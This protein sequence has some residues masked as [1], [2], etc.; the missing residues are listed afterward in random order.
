M[1]TFIGG[2]NKDTELLAQPEGTYRDALNI[3]LNY[4]QGSVLNEEGVYRVTSTDK[5]IV[6]GFCV[7][8][9]DRIV[10][11]G[12]QETD[13][14]GSDGS[15]YTYF[16]QIKLLFP[17]EDYSIIL[18]EDS[19]LNFRRTHRVQTTHRK[20]QAGETLVYFTD[21]Y[22]EEGETGIESDPN[23]LVDFNP[24]RVF[25]VDKQYERVTKFDEPYT[26]LYG[27]SRFDADNLRLTPYIGPRAS[28]GIYTGEADGAAVDLPAG[29]GPKILTGGAL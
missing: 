23:Y 14:L 9:D 25:N 2:M 7:L 19:K 3:N 20:N 27:Q 18:Y 17:K 15:N 13:E 16:N 28:F 8:D 22:Y 6:C 10:L 4:T 21:G 11:F 26:R 24:P 12:R 29:D 1:K 5:F